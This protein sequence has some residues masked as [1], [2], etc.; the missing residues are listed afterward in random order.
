MSYSRVLGDYTGLAAPNF[1]RTDCAPD[2]LECPNCG[3]PDNLDGKSP[4]STNKPS[5][6]TGIM[7]HGHAGA[8]PADLR[9]GNCHSTKTSSGWTGV[10]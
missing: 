8:I 6:T 4:K 10:N 9:R 7:K 1:Y 2:G 5:T 3:E